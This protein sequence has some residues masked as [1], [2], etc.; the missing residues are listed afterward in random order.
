[1][2]YEIPVALI[3]EF[4]IDLSVIRLIRLLAS[5][6]PTPGKKVRRWRY[7]SLP[8]TTS[9]ELEMSKM[10]RGSLSHPSRC[11]WS[12]VTAF[13]RMPRHPPPF[14]PL[15]DIEFTFVSPLGCAP[16]V[17]WDRHG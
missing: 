16:R 2:A 17:S 3:T 4:I 1:M 11:E 15:L 5:A 14:F 12:A 10:D 8:F 7:L 9:S 13:G 6:G